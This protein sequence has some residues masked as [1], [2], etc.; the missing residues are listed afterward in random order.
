MILLDTDVMVDI[1][2]GH[3]PAVNW[4]RAAAGQEVGLPGLVVMELV[5]GCQGARE[6]RKLEKRL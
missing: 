2:R 5:Q 4:L 1:L 6:Q 3:E